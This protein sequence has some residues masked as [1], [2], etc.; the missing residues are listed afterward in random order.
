MVDINING[1]LFKVAFSTLLSLAP[2]ISAAVSSTKNFIKSKKNYNRI[3]A[4]KP[5]ISFYQ[6]T[7]SYL[8]K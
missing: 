6:Q 8:K 1:S 7:S 3:C 5:L 2:Q 4:F